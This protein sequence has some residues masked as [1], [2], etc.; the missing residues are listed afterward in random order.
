MIITK[1]DPDTGALQGT[2]EGSAQD[3]FA[4]L[5]PGDVFI[6]GSHD[7]D[8]YYISEASLVARPKLPDPSNLHILANDIETTRVQAVPPGTRVFVS[9]LDVDRG[10]PEK[11]NLAT[12]IDDGEFEW[13]TTQ[14]GRYEV[15]IF[16]PFPYSHLKF[17]VVAYAVP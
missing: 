7:P 17:E 5:Q 1:Y 3:V 15:A 14:P 13:S 16:P 6:E 9:R 12:I 2:L 8:R 11:D 10:H 4:S